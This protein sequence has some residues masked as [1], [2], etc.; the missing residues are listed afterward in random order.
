MTGV[1]YAGVNYNTGRQ[2]RKKGPRKASN[3]NNWMKGLGSTSTLCGWV[4]MDMN[5]TW[6]RGR[7]EPKTP[8]MMYAEL[9]L[10]PHGQ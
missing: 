1:A 8:Q 9:G 5:G 6:R 4:G 10:S 3:C 7:A 2:D